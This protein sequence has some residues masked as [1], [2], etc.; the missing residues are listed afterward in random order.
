VHSDLLTPEVLDKESTMVRI[1]ARLS[2]AGL[3]TFGTLTSLFSKI[4]A[5]RD[6]S[7]MLSRTVLSWQRLN[8]LTCTHC[9]CACL[10]TL[11]LLHDV[12]SICCRFMRERVSLRVDHVVRWCSGV[13]V[14]H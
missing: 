2:V 4:G 10:S 12:L 8:P 13:V 1:G 14:D 5:L 11:C 7:R 9:L 6:P 3:L